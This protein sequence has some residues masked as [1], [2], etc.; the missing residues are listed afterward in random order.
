M[1]IPVYYSLEHTLSDSLEQDVEQMLL[2]D[3]PVI[4]C[5]RP[6]AAFSCPALAFG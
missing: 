6:E 4:D 5:N 2:T 3:R 1:K